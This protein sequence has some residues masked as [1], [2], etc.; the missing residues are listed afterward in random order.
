MNHLDDEEEK[1]DESS[2]LIKGTQDD[3]SNIF[4]I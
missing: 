3:S 1:F 4:I 2:L